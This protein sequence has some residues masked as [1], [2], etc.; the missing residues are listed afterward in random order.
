MHSPGSPKSC[1]GP[2]FAG[3]YTDSVNARIIS[4]V[5]HIFTPFK[6]LFSIAST[7]HVLNFKLDKYSA[8]QCPSG[9]AKVITDPEMIEAIGNGTAR[10]YILY[11][12]V[13]YAVLKVPLLQT[14]RVNDSTVIMSAS[15]AYICPS[16]LVECARALA[17]PDQYTQ[18]GDEIWLDGHIIPNLY[19]VILPNKDV[20]FCYDSLKSPLTLDAQFTVQE[21]VGTSGQVLSGICLSYIVITY[22]VVPSLRNVSGRC[23]LNLSVTLL[24]AQVTF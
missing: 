24:L 4:M 12:G 6:M 5:S 1:Y 3:K 14:Y 16:P 8:M 19:Y 17:F 21:I 9:E 7:T 13:Y 20:V 22:L 11:N 10:E 2:N 23:I 18:H 15:K